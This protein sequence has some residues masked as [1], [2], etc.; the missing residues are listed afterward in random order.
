[1]INYISV[2]GLRFYAYHGCLEE[3]GR[4]GGDYIVDVK[5][6]TD[7]IESAETDSLDK[8]ID[9]CIVYEICKREMAVRSKL[10]E[11]VCKRIF[12]SLASE[13]QGIQH[14]DVRVVKLNP[15]MN[16]DVPQVSVQMADK[17]H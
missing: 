8:T 6:Q 5:M 15:P 4:V 10:I 3:E 12:N 13:L 7:F 1:M 17:L 16:G 9:Y 14:L 11:T 2:E